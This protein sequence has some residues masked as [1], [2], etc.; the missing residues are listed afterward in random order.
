MLPETA[1]PQSPTPTSPTRYWAFLDQYMSKERQVLWMKDMLVRGYL[2][3]DTLEPTEEMRSM[4]KG[5]AQ[6]AR[7]DFIKRTVFHLYRIAFNDDDKSDIYLREDIFPGFYRRMSADGREI[8]QLTNRLYDVF[9]GC[10]PNSEVKTTISNIMAN[11]TEVA[12]LDNGLFKVADNLYWDSRRGRLEP[13]DGLSGREAFREIGATASN[14]KIVPK[15]ITGSFYKWQS[16]LDPNPPEDTPFQEFYQTLP[17]E[18]PFIKVWADPDSEGYVDKYWDLCI[19]AATNFMYQKPP[20]A[21]L[22]I[23]NPRGGKSTY[24]KMLHYL[25]GA[26]QTTRNTLADLAD[27]SSNNVLAGSLLNAPDEDP[28]E[29]LSPEATAAF[30]SI[31]A[32]EE[33]LVKVKFSTRPKLVKPNFML[34]IPKN[35]VPNFGADSDACMT[36]IRPIFF[37]ADLSKLDNKPK[38]FIKETFVDNPEM[39]AEFVGFL[40]ALASY[41]ETHEMWWSDTM[42]NSGNYISESVNSTKLYYLAWKKFYVGYGSFNLLW[43][44]Y[45]N[46]CRSRGYEIEGKESLRQRFFVEGQNRKRVYYPP[47]K[48][49]IWAYLTDKEYGKASYENGKNLLVDEEKIDSY[50]YAKVAVLEHGMSFVDIRLAVLEAALATPKTVKQSSFGRAK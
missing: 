25:I 45:C 16:L 42:T 38:D 36:R 29:K 37:T 4:K 3:K 20:K 1:V 32:H 44:D 11:I 18:F 22:E 15:R 6:I 5:A 26:H 35:S 49:A 21:Y 10:T 48:T 43:T 39:T 12:D 2:A 13:Q 47:M 27:W 34:F 8:E 7:D 23:G 31:A 14:N 50:G 40:L 28:A 19:A 9:F 24:N 30:K 17:M 41:F 46:F 33:L